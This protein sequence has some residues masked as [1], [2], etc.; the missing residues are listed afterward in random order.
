VCDFPPQNVLDV[1]LIKTTD[2]TQYR[3]I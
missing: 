3:D 1:P 2:I